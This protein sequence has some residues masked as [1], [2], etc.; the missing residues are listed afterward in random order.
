MAACGCGKCPQEPIQIRSSIFFKLWTWLQGCR[1]NFASPPPPIPILIV[2]ENQAMARGRGQNKP[3]FTLLSK[4]SISYWFSRRDKLLT[5]CFWDVVCCIS[6]KFL[7][8]F[9]LKIN[10]VFFPS[11]WLICWP[12]VWGYT[13]LGWIPPPLTLSQQA[14]EAD[15]SS[16]LPSINQK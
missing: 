3:R 7:P 11:L 12:W 15:G 10:D 9:P 8:S 13:D 2:F 4:T 6:V 16:V 14:K 5:N 1:V